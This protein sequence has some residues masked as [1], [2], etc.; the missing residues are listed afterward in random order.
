MSTRSFTKAILPAVLFVTAVTFSPSLFNGFSKNDDPVHLLENPTIRSLSPENFRAMFENIINTTYIPLTTVSYA[1]EYHFFGYNPFVYHLD[2]LLLH[3]A[4]TALIFMFFRRL[5]FAET[6]AGIGALIFGI[7][8]MHVESVAWI[9]ERKDVLY[10]VFYMSSVLLYLRYVSSENKIF[11][12]LSLG[13]CFLSVLAKP[14]AL[15]LPLILLLCDWWKGRRLTKAVFMEKILYCMIVAGVAFI[16]YTYNARVPWH[17]A[18]Q[19]LMLWIWCFI[20]YLKKFI[21]PDPL[22]IFY[23]FPKPLTWSNPEF[24]FSALVFGAILAALY[25]FRKHKIFVFAVCFYFFS[26]FFLLRFDDL[27]NIN[28]VSDRFMYLPGVGFCALLGAG[29]ASWIEDQKL[30]FRKNVILGLAVI[31]VLLTVKTF[32]QNLDWRDGS[33]LWSAVIH[34]SPDLAMAYVHRGAEYHEKGDLKAAAEDYRKAIVLKDDAY[35]HSN[36]AMIYKEEKRY[37][38][39]ESEYAKAVRIKPDFW[40]AFYDRGNLYKDTGRFALAVEDYTKAIKLLPGFAE[41]YANRGTAHFYNGE[42]DLA[43]SDFNRAIRF[44]PRSIN[45]INNRAVIFAKQNKFKK[46]IA[47]FTTS[48]AL[49]PG[50]APVYF[51]RGLAYSQSGRIRS[52]LEDFDRALSLNPD[53]KDAYE[54]KMRLMRKNGSTLVEQADHAGKK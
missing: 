48:I 2:N 36:L 54:Q 19:A 37:D 10:A 52:A 32:R 6:A 46:A 12:W 18:G 4:V 20:F 5:G 43:L 53:Y 24:F 51:N 31:L 23:Q 45:A 33:K 13:L 7:H 38:E 14:M 22:C 26:I 28:P 42:D 47:D 39:A 3:L 49:D 15:S 50:N 30:R 25:Y 44:D 35:A 11:Y 40:G 29:F 17:S 21:W 16:T 34:N 27:E 9:T 1:L 41:A 8:P